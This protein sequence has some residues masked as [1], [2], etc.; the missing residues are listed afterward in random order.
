MQA[1]KVESNEDEPLSSKIKSQTA[2]DYDLNEL[3]SF[4]P[5]Y[6]TEH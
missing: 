3:R 5:D 1:A 6:E 2:L 4:L